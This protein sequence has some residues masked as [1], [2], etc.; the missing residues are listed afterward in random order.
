[1]SFTIG[2]LLVILGLILGSFMAA[3]IFRLRNK[4]GGLL[5]GRSFCANCKTTLQPIDLIPVVS[6]LFLRGKCRYC[7]KPIPRSCLWIE[8]ITALVFLT[9]GYFTGVGNILLL[10]WQLLFSSVLVFIAAYDSLYGEIPDEVSLPAIV[11]ALLGSFLSFTPSFTSSLL[12]FAI[13]ALPFFAI[14]F[15]SRGKWMGGGDSRLGGLLG[16]LLGWQQ[17]LIAIFLAA[18]CGSIVGLLLIAQNKKQLT[19]RIPFGPYLAVGGFFTM[20]FGNALW[21]WYAMNFLF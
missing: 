16:I 10:F 15:F 13:G 3:A 18:S 2:L 20:L 5:T 8:I 19:S 4:T 11:I 14:F 12:G 17:L 9:V 21:N 1:L 7:G 6:F